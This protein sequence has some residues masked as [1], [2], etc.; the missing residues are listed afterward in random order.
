MKK[1][2]LIVFLL[3]TGGVFGWLIY[4]FSEKSD[5]IKEAGRTVYV[6][7]FRVFDAFEMKQEYDSLLE[8]ELEAEKQQLDNAYAIYMEKMKVSGSVKEEVESTYYRAREDYDRK[9]EKLSGEYTRK[10]YD[11]LS[12]YIKEFGEKEGYVLILGA[13]SEGV[14][15]YASP[16]T[17]VTNQLIAFVNKKYQND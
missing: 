16:E 5:G 11:R 3:I 2:F 17:D 1:Y 9:L 10:V 13:G 7:K 15:M 8:K 14:L 12:I 6:D 4:H